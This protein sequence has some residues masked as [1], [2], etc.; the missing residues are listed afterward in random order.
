MKNNFTDF[1]GRHY[2][3]TGASSGIGKETA[4]LLASFGAKVTLTGR[5]EEKLQKVKENLRGKNHA[6]YVKDLSEPADDIPQWLKSIT[7]EEGG[8]DGL[9]HCAGFNRIRTLVSVKQNSL[10]EMMQVHF[11]SASM[12]VKAFSSSSNNTGNNNSIV[13]AGSAAALMGSKGQTAYASAKGALISASRVWAMELAPKKIRV[14][15]ASFG[16]IETEMIDDFKNTY[17]EETVKAIEKRHP[18]GFGNVHDAANVIVFL[19]SEASS[20][21]TGQNIVADGGLTINDL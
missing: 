2:F 20:F 14:N 10:E 3:V 13:L 9:V 11:Y 4:Q 15:V 12:L 18:L 7:K 16:F 6:Y 8:F 1:S 19:L 5:N 21:V 17:P